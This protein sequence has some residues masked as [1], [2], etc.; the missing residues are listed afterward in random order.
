MSIVDQI[1]DFE[2]GNMS[3]EDILNF[4]ADLIKSGQ[5]W[6][7]QGSYG[8]FANSLIQ[9]GLIDNEGNIIIEVLDFEN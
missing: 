3:D 1:M 6:T 7:L 5:A 9:N 4:F 2:G 8:R